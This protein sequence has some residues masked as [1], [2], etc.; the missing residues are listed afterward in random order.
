MSLSRGEVD[1]QSNGQP[2]E[3]PC[4]RTHCQPLSHEQLRDVEFAS[5][6]HGSRHA[7]A[8]QRMSEFV[9]SPRKINQSQSSQTINLQLKKHAIYMGKELKCTLIAPLLSL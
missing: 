4:M 9:A 8:Y 1:G 6:S 7:R 3:T 5:T 2:T